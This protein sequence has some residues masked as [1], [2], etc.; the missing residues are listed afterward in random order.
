M[1]STLT[2]CRLLRL[3]EISWSEAGV[4]LGTADCCASATFTC[5]AAN[6]PSQSRY[7]RQTGRRLGKYHAPFFCWNQIVGNLD[8][9]NSG[10]R[11]TAVFQERG[12]RK[13]SRP[14]P[15]N[16]QGHELS[17]PIFA[18]GAVSGHW[19]GR[20]AKA[21]GGTGGHRGVRRQWD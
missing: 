6:T 21:G 10:H 7:R 15:Y 1:L 18:A 5:S 3:P 4:G 20:T 11:C 16:K 19:R 2:P 8:G 13:P 12:R 17:G 9:S 14:N